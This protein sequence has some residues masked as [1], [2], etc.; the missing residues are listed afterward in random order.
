[1]SARTYVV[2]VVVEEGHVVEL[3]DDAAK[4]HVARMNA[5]N[6]VFT[7]TVSD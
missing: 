2:V 3:A 6:N 7:K 4:G 1:M 5:S